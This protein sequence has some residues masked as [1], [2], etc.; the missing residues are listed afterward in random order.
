MMIITICIVN[1]T[2]DQKFFPPAMASFEGLSPGTYRA[3][4]VLPQQPLPTTEALF[5]AALADAS[6]QSMSV[7]VDEGQTATI[8]WDLP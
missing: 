2:S 7:I 8:T 1:G 5:Q 3:M 4:R 6:R